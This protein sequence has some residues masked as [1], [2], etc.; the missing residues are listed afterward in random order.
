MYS[1]ITT[2]M[3][4]GLDAIPVH[5]EADVSE[6]LPY[7]IHDGAGHPVAGLL[8]D[9]GDGIRPGTQLSSKLLQGPLPGWYPVG[10]SA[11]NRLGGDR[12]RSR[13]R[14]VGRYGAEE[15]VIAR[16]RTGIAEGVLALLRWIINLFLLWEP[17]L[18]R[19]LIGSVQ[20]YD[21]ADRE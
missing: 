2:A 10:E 1:V 3:N 6:G 4:Y 14:G 9:G 5:V 15:S 13:N 12:E 21:P 18:R 8:G 19:P 16:E 11:K 20:T 17:G 7:G